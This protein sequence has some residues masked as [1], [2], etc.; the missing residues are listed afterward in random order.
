[1]QTNNTTKRK[2]P[3]DELRDGVVN[4]FN[5]SDHPAE[6]FSLTD[7]TVSVA[8]FKAVFFDD[9]EIQAANIKFQ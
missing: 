3:K 1:M 9:P 4:V 7:P 5:N 6:S 8:A 2:L